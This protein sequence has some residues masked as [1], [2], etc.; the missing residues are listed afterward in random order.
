MFD[1][2][3]QSLLTLSRHFSSLD[4]QHRLIRFLLGFEAILQQR[5]ETNKKQQTDL[6]NYKEVLSFYKRWP[7]STLYFN[8]LN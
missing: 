4:A 5:K 1:N 3:Q 8:R 2:R 6:Q 7:C